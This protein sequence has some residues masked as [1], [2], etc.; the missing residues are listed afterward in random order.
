MND[1]RSLKKR[2]KNWTEKYAKRND[3]NAVFVISLYSMSLLG[4]NRM[5]LVFT[6]LL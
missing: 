1:R 5:K 4:V 2:G 6:E 3:R